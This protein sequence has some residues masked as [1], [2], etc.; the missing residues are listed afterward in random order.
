MTSIRGHL[1]KGPPQEASESDR[2]HSIDDLDSLDKR[3]GEKELQ[4]L[5]DSTAPD[6]RLGEGVGLIDSED[7]RP[8]KRT[9]L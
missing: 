1:K 2:S 3:I 7:L 6:Q 4:E 8:V 5:G 9:K